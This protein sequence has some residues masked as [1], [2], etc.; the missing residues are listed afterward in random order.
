MNKSPNSYGNLC[1]SFCGKSQKEV[2]KL[3]AGPGVYICDECIDLCNDIITEEKEREDIAKHNLKVP[4]PVDI[5]TFL[6]DFVI[7]QESA[8]KSLSVAVH[9]HYKRINNSR[10]KK[11]DDVEIAK[12]NILLIGPTGSGKTLLAQTIAKILNVPFAMAD[13][14]AL[15]EAGYVGEDVENVVLNLLQASDYDV[16]KCKKGVIYIDE[17]DKISRKSENPSITRDVSGEGV[18][19]AL[20]KILEGTVANLPPKGG[21][22]HPQQEFI[23]VDT[24]N[25]L[26]ICGGAFV[27]LDKVIE[28]RLSNRSLG[29][30]AD[31]KTK[32]EKDKAE[33]LLKKVE[34]DDLVKFGLIPEFIGRLPVVATLD[35]LTEDAL[36]DILIRPKNALTKQFQKLLDYENCHLTFTDSALREIAREAIKRN[37]GARGL[38]SVIEH[39][40]LDV[41]YEIPS[42]GNVKECIID[43]GTILRGEKPKLVIRTEREM[44]QLATA[45]TD[46]SAESA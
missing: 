39:A 5:K 7:G 31:I 2:K 22:K 25:I 40:M 33:N 1:C 26:F 8:K 34:P 4:K 38:R 13:A 12:S 46:D 6:D 23:Q 45:K 18:Q 29:I 3:I 42:K 32:A 41:M 16:E 21:R 10:N 30:N 28:N 35:Q 24:S 15:T 14:T 27:G 11:K 37:T 44:A 43:E 36:V 19:Q 20:L 17:I 9:N